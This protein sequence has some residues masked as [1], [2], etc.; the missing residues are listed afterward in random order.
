M[1]TEALFKIASTWK[2][3]KCPMTEEWIKKPWYVYITEYYSVIKNEIM[4]FAATQLDLEIIIQREVK[5]QYH[6]MLL[7][8]GIQLFSKQLQ[9][10]LF[11][12][13]KQTYRQQ[14]QTYGYQRENKEEG[15]KSG[16]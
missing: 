16:A 6:I 15:D 11:T 3:P 13:Q 9:M 4:P 14:K 5:D 2:Q 8:C 12:K 7:I 10:N 1:F